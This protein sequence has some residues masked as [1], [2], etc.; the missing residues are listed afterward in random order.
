M[1]ASNMP[2]IS[3]RDRRKPGLDTAGSVHEILKCRAM[4]L[5]NR[6]H[7]RFLKELVNKY[8]QAHR[9]LTALNRRLSEQQDRL[10]LDLRAAAGIQK[11]LLPQMLPRIPGLDMAWRFIP[12]EIIGGDVFNVFWLDAHHLG[13]YLLDV[14]GHGV[15]AALVTVSVSQMLLP[16][17]G[18]VMRKNPASVS[19]WEIASPKD[20]MALLDRE[21]PLERF[22]AFFSMIYI[23]LDVRDGSFATCNAGHMPA[24]LLRRDGG[25]EHL[26]KGGTVIGLGDWVPFEQQEQKLYKG[27]RLLLYSDGVTD[28]MNSGQ[29]LFGKDRFIRI[30]GSLRNKPMEEMVGGIYEAMMTFGGGFPIQDDV[31][32]LGLARDP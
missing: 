6:L 21:Y 20:V 30:A 16:H 14:S 10:D 13:I 2:D 11:S 5:D 17:T 27:D 19:G 22:D 15:Q 31:S 12:S 8:S 24:L 7:N 26:K 25:I 3:F 9:K 23:V 18:F 4:L 28:F 1:T 29:E 32:I